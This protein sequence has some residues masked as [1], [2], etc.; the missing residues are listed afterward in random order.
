M[1]ERAAMFKG[2]ARER[3]V[4]IAEVFRQLLPH[5]MRHELLVFE[6]GIRDKASPDL[7][8]KLQAHE[9]RILATVIGVIRDAVV[10]GDLS[11]PAGLPPEKL[12]LALLQVDI[13]AHVLKQRPI[14]YG[15]FSAEDAYRVL[16]DFG[17]SLA[18]S[19]GWRPL[20]SDYDYPA[21]MRRMWREVFPEE[22]ARFD[23]RL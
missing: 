2:R 21:A 22:L 10:S 4:A 18:D 20:S 13:G 19:L 17:A 12:G 5:H 8:R 3:V 23:V 16:L 14:S 9:D 15:R 7:L 1:V 11:L 6:E